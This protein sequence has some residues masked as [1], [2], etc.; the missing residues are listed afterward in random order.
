MYITQ[1]RI[2]NFKR[3]SDRYK[4]DLV[5]GTNILVGP[6]E[7]GK[8]TI[9]EAIHLALTG[10]YQGRY[11]RNDISQY[12][13]NQKVVEQYLESVQ[14]GKAQDPPSLEIELLFDDCPMTKGNHNSQL[15]EQTGL[16][17]KICF[18]DAQYQD[19][20]NTLI[21]K[22]DLITLPVEYYHVVWRFF[23]RDDITSRSIPYKSSFIDT[24]IHNQS[25]SD[26][27]ISHI[28]KNKLDN[29]DKISITQSYRN[30]Q[31]TFMADNAIKGINQKLAEMADID[32]QEITLSIDLSSR[33]AWE[34]SLT[35]YLEKIPFHYVGKGSQCLI[36]TKLALAQRDAEEQGIV[37][38]EEPEN[39]LSYVKLNGLI[40]TINEQVSTQQLVITTHSS[41]VLNKLKLSSPTLLSG[42]DNMR[43]NNLSEETVTYFEKLAGYDT[44]RLL[45]CKKAIL[46]E[47]DSDEL[48]IQRA[49][50]D[51]Y[52]HL[53]IE[54]GVDVLC[55][56]GLAFL[57]FLEIA[58]S[59]N[60]NVA[61]ITDNDGDIAA[62]QEKYQNYLGANA[63]PNIKICYDEVVNNKDTFAIPDGD[64][65]LKETF[66]FN[67]L[68][69][70]MLKA[71]GLEK[72]KSIFGEAYDTNAKMLRHLH[73]N[74]GL[75][76]LMFFKT[77][78]ALAYPAY[79]TKAVKWAL[80]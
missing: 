9:V 59:L 69:P 31:Q 2:H 72:L 27:Y 35:A 41:F 46:V 21:A 49:Y 53:P 36:K 32:G 67:T 42:T 60:L 54:D 52:G 68:E 17:Y 25:P 62:L 5:P 73:A 57:R 12:L 29:A 66:N 38:I 79:I 78:K 64:T 39:H 55:V 51:E 47:G 80:E 16:Y 40:R 44:L 24:A 4:I 70:Q 33:R 14:Q 13:F 8:S 56:R 23:H 6:N 43:I 63:V 74:K 65:T 61:V 18:D 26:L 3:F 45:L 37:L 71:N 77:D 20:Y 19:E 10:F 7:V 1:V 34:D 75:S 15:V 30:A 28:I 48:V 22:R 11:V 58:K 50:K 76:G